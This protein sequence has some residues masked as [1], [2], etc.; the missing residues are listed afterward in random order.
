MP[1]A[2][3]QLIACGQNRC[4]H[5]V[6][7]DQAVSGRAWIVHDDLLVHPFHRQLLPGPGRIVNGEIGLGTVPHPA[8][9]I[10]G[11]AAPVM[12]STQAA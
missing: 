10:Q 12:L 5:G 6:S 11:E 3:H 1:P 9:A 2:Q 4:A 7:I 8:W